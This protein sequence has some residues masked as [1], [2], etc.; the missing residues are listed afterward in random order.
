[1]QK[2]TTWKKFH[3][4]YNFFLARRILSHFVTFF[5]YCVLIPLSVF[6]PEVEIPKWGMVY[7]PSIITAFNAVGTPRFATIY[8]ALFFLLQPRWC[9]CIHRQ[10][11]DVLVIISLSS[12]IYFVLK[13]FLF[14]TTKKR[15]F[16]RHVRYVLPAS[17]DLHV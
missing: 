8:R 1:M 14:F 17:L 13:I 15:I 11:R 7:V 9:S 6:F 12:Y 16:P 4:I 10:R 3:V 2:V 5:F